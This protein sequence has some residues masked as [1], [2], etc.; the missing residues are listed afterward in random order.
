MV[1]RW[2]LTGRNLNAYK[3]KWYF[4]NKERSAESSRKS[5]ARRRVHD[6]LYQE[7][8]IWYGMRKRCTNPK[9]K[10]FK[11]YGGRGIKIESAWTCFAD[12]IRDVGPR[13]SKKHSID[14]INN[15]GNYGWKMD[16]KE[17]HSDSQ[18]VS[19]SLSSTVAWEIEPSNKSAG[20]PYHG[21]LIHPKLGNQPKEP[22]ADMR[23]GT[24][25]HAM[26]LGEGKKY[27]V[28][29]VFKTA[30]GEI[31][32]GWKSAEAKAWKAEIESQGI[33]PISRQE[34]TDAQD[35]VVE[36]SRQIHDFGLGYLLNGQNYEKW[37]QWEERIE[38]N[39]TRVEDFLSSIECRAMI[40]ILT[41]DWREIWDVKTT[42]CVHESAIMN[43]ILKEGLPLRSEFYKLAAIRNKPELA[44]KVKH[45]FLF[46]STEKKHGYAVVPV[47]E[48]DGRFQLIGRKQVERSIQTWGE[49]L[50]KNEWPLYGPIKR[51]ECPPFAF[52][53]E[54]EEEE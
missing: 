54:I 13:P 34:E 7:K 12:F 31:S 9:S 18:S 38:N 44:G 4:D 33:L 21:W 26:L 45:G 46:C 32:D 43:K 23:F 28:A 17:Y 25:C 27:A 10:D 41:E 37:L 35:C 16:A 3:R 14:R 20:T 6:Q 36:W 22:T 24:L 15:D 29:P 51:L 1:R 8:Q 19:P 11:H 5:V 40:D 2:H 52:R 47:Y 53:D 49:C 42:T 48:L 30:K 39:V 50:R